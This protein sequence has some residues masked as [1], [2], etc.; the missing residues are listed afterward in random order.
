MPG[1]GTIANAVGILLGGGLGLLLKKGMPK[2]VSDM[3]F[4][5]SAT[6]VFLIGVTGVVGAAFTVAEDGSLSSNYM[7]TLLLCLVAGGAIGELMRIDRGFDAVGE[8]IKKALSGSDSRS[9]EGFAITT[10]MFCAGAMAILGSIEDGIMG[11]PATLYTKA[12]LDGIT[13]MVFASTYGFGVLL[14]AGSVLVYQ[15][16]LTLLSRFIEPLMTPV[17]TSQM[18]LVGSAIIMLIAFNTWGIKK[19]NI[20]NL[21]PAAFL[22]LVISLVQRTLS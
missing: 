21:I 2:R 19:F 10:V 3:I 15:G 20:A 12:V 4:D 11:S 18:S 16:T 17:V 7:I 6:A 8:K 13:A 9:S 22:P 14:S 1:I 5:C